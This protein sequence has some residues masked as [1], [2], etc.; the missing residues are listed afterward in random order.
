M[1]WKIAFKS[2]VLILAAV[3]MWVTYYVAFIW[4]PGMRVGQGFYP[5]FAYIVLLAFWGAV[6]C[7]T[8]SKWWDDWEK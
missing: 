5:F 8:P 6:Y 4:E 2:S 3:V 7:V 1:L